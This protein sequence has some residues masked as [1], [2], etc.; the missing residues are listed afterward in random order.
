MIILICVAYS[1]C[2]CITIA[3]A[4]FALDADDP[5]DDGSGA[6]FAI[7]AGVIWP[8]VWFYSAAAW[9]ERKIMGWSKP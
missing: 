1:F 5:Q 3:W 7:L 2:A 6:V 9:C 4:R 8:L